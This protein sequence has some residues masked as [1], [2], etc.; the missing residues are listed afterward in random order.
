MCL[1][2]KV[3]IRTKN[4]QRTYSRRN[5][6]YGIKQPV[7][8]QTL[9]SGVRIKNSRMHTGIA[10]QYTAHAGTAHMMGLCSP[11][12]PATSIVIQA[13]PMSLGSQRSHRPITI[14]GSRYPRIAKARFGTWSWM[15][16]TVP[17]GLT[18]ATLSS[19]SPAFGLG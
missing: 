11:E 1:F 9:K 6:V 19:V 14:S 16:R 12:V 17:R 8:I 10:R 2:K 5:A 7:Y 15:S 4:K 3:S 13:Y 18:P